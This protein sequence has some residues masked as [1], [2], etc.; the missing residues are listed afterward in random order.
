MDFTNALDFVENKIKNLDDSYTFI[1]TGD[2]ILPNVCWESLCI[3]SGYPLV[4]SDTANYLLRFMEKY[5]LNQCINIPTRENN[6]LDLLLTNRHD[7]VLDVLAAK[8]LISDHNVIKIPLSY[9]FESAEVT[10]SNNEI[11]KHEDTFTSLDFSKADFE[12]LSASFG[13]CDWD[14]M[15]T[16]SP[17]NFAFNFHSKVLNLF[18]LKVFQRNLI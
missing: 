9:T 11:S 3:E 16:E 10:K 14:S 18:A 8:S 15:F 6:I 7:L 13:A 5:L 17:E 12:L 4:L 2:F 1:I